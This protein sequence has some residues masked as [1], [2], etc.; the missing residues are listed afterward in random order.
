[1]ACA[2]GISGGAR[3]R[4]VVDLSNRPHFESNIPLDEEYVGGDAYA[5]ATIRAGGNAAGEVGRCGLALTCEM[6][7]HTFTSL[8]I[9]SRSTVHVELL[10]DADAGKPGG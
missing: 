9:E 8:A 3:V 6:L 2:E 10:D 7:D 5:E 1:M 4:V